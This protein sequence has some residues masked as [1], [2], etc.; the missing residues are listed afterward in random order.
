VSSL[1]THDLATGKRRELAR[2]AW[3]RYATM[4]N[5]EGANA[6]AAFEEVV[7]ALLEAQDETWGRGRTLS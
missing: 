3:D 1:N 5:D 2:L 4:V 7:L 6:R